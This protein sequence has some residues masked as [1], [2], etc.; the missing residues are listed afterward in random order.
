M[1]VEQAKDAAKLVVEA[2]GVFGEIWKWLIGVLG[3]GLV[4][5]WGHITGRVA[6]L[7]KNQVTEA[8]LQKH[9]N[10]EDEKF[11]VLFDK[12]ERLIEKVS[13]IQS[14][15]ARIEGKLDR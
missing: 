12:N 3:A 11:N 10:I 1:P 8:R 6:A 7:E 2:S 15:V 14:S 4:G 5:L 9:E 13:E